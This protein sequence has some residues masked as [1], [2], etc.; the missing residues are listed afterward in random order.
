MRTLNRDFK[1]M[2]Q[3]NRDGSFATQHDR[4]R[5]LTMVANQLREDGFKNLRAQGI[6]TKH[7][8]HLVSRWQAEGASTGTMKN[9]M[10]ALRWM[11]EKIGKENIVARDNV[12]Y[13]IADRRFVT[14]ESKAKELDQGKLDKVSDPYTAMSLRLQEAF[15]LRREESI[16]I[17]PGWADRGDVLVLKSTW[18][19]GGKERE[20]PILNEMQR[21]LMNQA[22]A[23]AD[24]G[25]LI[26]VEMSYKDQLN[27]FKAQTAFAGIDRVHGFRHAYAQARYA[28]LTGWKAPAAG[29]PT[30]KQLSPEQKA[31]DRQARLT[32][33]RELGHEREQITAVYLGR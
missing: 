9:R 2:C 13:G 22:K 32:I 6:R 28:E 24:K 33:S 11:A 8:E 7:I 12:A 21:E 3:R 25:S 18:T 4:E 1:L 5:L 26:P 29:G 14:N 17:Q 16:K 20:I 30:S 27:R 23:L 19:K 31:I 10:S 15:G